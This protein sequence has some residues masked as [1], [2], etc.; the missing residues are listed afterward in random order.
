VSGNAQ[1]YGDAWVSGNAQVY[2]DAWVASPLYIQGSRHA[3]T[4]CSFTQIAVGCHV[5]DIPDW[6]N[7]FRV[8]GRVECYTEEQIEEYGV[9][10]NLMA[11]TAKRLH[12]V[13]KKER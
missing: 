3:L 1:V 13:N 12:A 7:R 2:G 10:L 6:L 9:Y 4:L 8:I 5:Y 11:E